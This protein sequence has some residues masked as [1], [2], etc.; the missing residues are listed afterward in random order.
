MLAYCDVTDQGWQSLHQPPDVLSLIVFPDWQCLDKDIWCQIQAPGAMGV[1]P[2]PPKHRPEILNTNALSCNFDRATPSTNLPTKSHYAKYH[3]TCNCA[4]DRPTH[5]QGWGGGTALLQWA[6]IN[7]CGMAWGVYDW[8]TPTW[9]DVWSSQSVGTA[10]NDVMWTGDTLGLAH[11][12]A[13]GKINSGKN[14]FKKIS[15]QLIVW[16]AE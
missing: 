7:L 14:I 13:P 2:P 16:N 6:L 15:G 4:I 3:A 8:P 10:C 9:H 1:T 5:C 11:S 12:L